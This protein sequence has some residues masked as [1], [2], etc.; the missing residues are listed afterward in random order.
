[1]KGE[2]GI[3]VKL[4][5]TLF[6]NEYIIYQRRETISEFYRCLKYL[7]EHRLENGSHLLKG[8]TTQWMNIWGSGFICK[9]CFSTRSCSHVEQAV[10][11]VV[12]S[13]CRQGLNKG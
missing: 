4:G 6:L 13:Y 8:T 2:D 11:T 5:T 9:G 3:H 12:H 1:M 7:R 10:C